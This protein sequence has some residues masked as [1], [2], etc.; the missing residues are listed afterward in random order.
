LKAF[1]NGRFECPFF[2]AAKKSNLANI[3]NQLIMEKEKLKKTISFRVKTK[4]YEIIQKL[5]KNEKNI[6]VFLRNNIIQSLENIIK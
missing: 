4:H 3:S 5:C 1:I 6:S 2:T